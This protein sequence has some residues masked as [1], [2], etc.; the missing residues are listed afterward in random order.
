MLL[1][2][3]LT[4][5][6]VHV[7]AFAP[8]KQPYQVLSPNGS[9]ATLVQGD[10]RRYKAMAAGFPDK[11]GFRQLRVGALG[12][13]W[14]DAPDIAQIGPAPP[15]NANWAACCAEKWGTKSPSC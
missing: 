12:L 9:A 15:K 11:P 14:L 4:L 8:E 13:G 7:T 6:L 3:V 1:P 2:P 10:R 5:I